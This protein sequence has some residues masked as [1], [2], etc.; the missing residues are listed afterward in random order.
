MCGTHMAYSCL[1]NR[2]AISLIIMGVCMYAES[3][4]WSLA[5]ITTT[6]VTPAHSPILICTAQEQQQ[7]Q[8][9]LQSVLCA[10]RTSIDKYRT[11]NMEDRDRGLMLVGFVA[12]LQGTAV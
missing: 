5:G 2:L 9:Q 12:E 1:N 10:V 3:P 7:Q 8:Q 11:C 6:F 4:R